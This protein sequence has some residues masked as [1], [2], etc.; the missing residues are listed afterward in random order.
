MS[1]TVTLEKLRDT[2]VDVQH[3]L[4]HQKND[5]SDLDK[6]ERERMEKTLTDAKIKIKDLLNDLD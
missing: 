4:A 6:K 3:A 5:L 2:V 1:E